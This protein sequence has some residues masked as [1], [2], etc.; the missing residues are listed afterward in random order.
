MY[1]ILLL[2]LLSNS[3]YTDKEDPEVHYSPVSYWVVFALRPIL[4]IHSRSQHRLIT[5]KHYPAKDHWVTTQ[6]GYIL[7]LQRIPHGKDG[8]SGG[9]VVF[10]QHC[11]LGASPDWLVNLANE[12]LA[13]IL[14]DAGFDVWLG[15][16][17]GNTYSKNHTHLKPSSEEFWDFRYKHKDSSTN[18]KRIKGCAKALPLP[19]LHLSVGAC[20]W[21]LLCS[22]IQAEF[23]KVIE[24]LFRHRL[25]QW[26]M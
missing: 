25:L 20:H 21:K 5:S 14:A 2:T 15:N 17:R 9:P 19:P 4:L 1:R 11:L 23:N 3:V 22:Y 7:N 13:F 8:A 16:V 18:L 24:T 6:D 26:C 10:L 12:S